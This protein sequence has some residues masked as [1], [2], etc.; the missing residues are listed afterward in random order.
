M[1]RAFFANSQAIRGFYYLNEY[2]YI[3]TES[4]LKEVTELEPTPEKA[5]LI[6]G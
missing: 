5:T 1:A 2:N 4:C 3:A 6:R